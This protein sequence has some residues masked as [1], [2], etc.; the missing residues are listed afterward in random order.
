MVLKRKNL[1]LEFKGG[2]VL[3][4]YS[5]EKNV[6]RWLGLWPLLRSKSS[7]EGIKLQYFNPPGWIIHYVINF[8]VIRGQKVSKGGH[9]LG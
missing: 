9:L 5:I 6:E 7:E 4:S 3:L 1:W 2:L 8:V